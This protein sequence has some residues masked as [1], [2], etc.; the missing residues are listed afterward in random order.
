MGGPGTHR[1]WHWATEPSCAGL[2][3]GYIGLILRGWRRVVGG[4]W[5]E[6]RGWRRVVGGGW[7]RCSGYPSDPLHVWRARV[8]SYCRGVKTPL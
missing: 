1:W 4:A 5:L 2:G 7:L 6:A 3:I 8:L